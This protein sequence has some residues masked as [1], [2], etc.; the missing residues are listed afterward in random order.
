MRLTDLGTG[1]DLGKIVADRAVVDLDWGVLGGRDVLAVTDVDGTVHVWDVADLRPLTSK[2]R[3]IAGAATARFGALDGQPALLVRTTAGQAELRH[4][5]LAT[6]V[7]EV[8]E[9]RSD[10]TSNVRYLATG[11]ADALDRD[12]EADAIAEILTSAKVQPPLAIGL[13]GEWGEGK[14]YF[15]QRIQRY[16]DDRTAGP[17]MVGDDVSRNVRQVS[18]NAWHYAETDLWASLV[19]HLFDQLAT[20]ERAQG[21]R[22]SSEG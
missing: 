15:M 18:F 17:T 5:A 19:F 4:L 16:V 12:R 8:P 22:W 9:Y 2:A 7:D 10:D 3:R 13:F 14:S 6:V 1:A 20:D 11:R 21:S